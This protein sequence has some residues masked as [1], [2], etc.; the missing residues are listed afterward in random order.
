MN[1]F[2][3]ASILP[4]ALLTACAPPQ[5]P[6]MT[7]PNFPSGSTQN[8]IGGQTPTGK[9]AGNAAAV[10]SWQLSG[11]MAAKGNGKAWSA[12]VNWQQYGMGSYNIR[13]FGPLGSGTVI[14]EKQGGMVTYKDGPKTATSKSAD[15]L[16]QKQT[17]IRLPINNFYYW[18]RGLPAPGGVQAENRDAANHLISLRQS[19]YTINYG[20]YTTVGNVDL[21]N[22]INLQGNGVTI[23][24]VIKHW[25]V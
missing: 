13:L 14:I 9:T 1:I 21:P 16:L 15:D 2:K 3:P 12:S 11:A 7:S 8:A 19:G 5:T 6:Q 22:K 23:K 24:L 4:L 10:N 18:V 17:G 20:G 25:N